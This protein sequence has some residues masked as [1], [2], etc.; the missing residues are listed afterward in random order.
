[1]DKIKKA[2]YWLYGAFEVKTL[3]QA[4]L[5]GIAPLAYMLF[6][7]FGAPKTMVYSVLC[8]LLYPFGFVVAKAI[9]NAVTGLFRHEYYFYSG[10]IR[11][12]AVFVKFI[13][14]LMLWLGSF[15]FSPAI[16]VIYGLYTLILLIYN[17][18]RTLN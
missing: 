6:A 12:M 16:A 17:K 9:L 1:M 15:L 5:V 3:V 7:W 11:M 18:N 10:L 13:L 2:Y 8:W 4:Y 14:L